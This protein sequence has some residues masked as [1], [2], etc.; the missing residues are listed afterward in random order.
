MDSSGAITP[1]CSRWCPVPDRYGENELPPSESGARIAD[2]ARIA[3]IGRC[4]LCDSDGYR[5]G[6]VCDH[7][8]HTEAAK[9]GMAM[10]RKAMGWTS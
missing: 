10:V 8:D 1:R 2:I 3:A 6:M 4:D 5:G 9:R 7:I